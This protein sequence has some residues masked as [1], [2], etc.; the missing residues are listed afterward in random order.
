[1]FKLKSC[2]ESF[3]ETARVRIRNELPTRATPARVF[4]IITTSDLESEWFP[5]FVSA[6]WLTP[7]PHGVGSLRLYRLKYMRI[8][9]RF[10]VWEPGKKLVFELEEC[11]LPII[12]RFMEHYEITPAADGGSLLVWQVSYQPNPWLAIFYPLVH[13]MFAADF[14]K[15]ARQ[16][17]ALLDREAQR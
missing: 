16:L 9:E 3:L 15:A 2:E 7:E 14:A 5:D 4:E 8:L 10:K 11:S 6:E 17:G 1:M 13:P 12:T